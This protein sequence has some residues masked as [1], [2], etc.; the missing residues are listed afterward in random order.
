M[1]WETQPSTLSKKKN[2]VLSLSIMFSISLPAITTLSN[3]P[4]NETK[5]AQVE[6]HTEEIKP[7]TGELNSAI[8][9]HRSAAQSP[10]YGL[11]QY[12]YSSPL[13]SER[14]ID[15][16]RRL[17]VIYIGAGISGIIA[18]IQFMKAVPDLDLVI[19]EKNP[20][21]GGTWY[22]NKYPGCACGMAEP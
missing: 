20:E 10:R 7:P 11:E 2:G 8:E 19:Y 21:L 18:G 14:A 9:M 5:T 13:I 16:P 1:P 3:N 22:E 15:Q 17:K 12:K 6:V 4:A